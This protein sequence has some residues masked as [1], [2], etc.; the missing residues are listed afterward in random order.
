[1]PAPS[2]N[3]LLAAAL[4]YLE[5]GWSILPVNSGGKWDKRPHQALK[6]TGHTQ[7]IDGET[8]AAWKLLQTERPTQEQVKK[9]F[10][11]EVGKGVALVTGAISGIV[12]LDF[13]GE[14]GVALMKALG[15]NPHART[16]SGGYHVYLK[17][18]GF[19]VQTLNSKAKHEL[20]ERWP[21]LDIRADGGYAILPPSRNNSGPYQQLRSF[22]DLDDVAVLPEELAAYLGLIQVQRPVTSPAPSRPVRQHFVPSGN[23]VPAELILERALRHV[24]G[25]GRNNAGMWLACQLRDNGYSEIESGAVMGNYVAQVPATNAKGQHEPYTVAEAHATLRSAYSQPARRPWEQSDSFTAGDAGLPAD[26]AVQASAPSNDL[27]DVGT[28][29]VVPSNIKKRVTPY[30]RS[31]ANKFVVRVQTELTEG[32][33]LKLR[34]EQRA[35]FVHRAGSEFARRLDKAGVEWYALIATL[36]E[37]APPEELLNQL[38]DLGLAVVERHLQGDAQYLLE[39]LPVLLDARAQRNVFYPI[40]LPQLDAALGGGLY[41]GLHVLGGATAGGKTALAL[42]AAEQNAR[43]ER[44]V[45]FV[46]YEQS[47]AELWTRLISSRVGISVSQLRKGGTAEEPVG[48]LLT[49]K[50]EYRELASSVAPYLRIFEGDG[51]SGAQQW[52]VERIAAE[53]R[54]VRATF[55]QSPLVI[56]DYLQRMP[57]QVDADKRH[58]IDEVVSAL[59]V[60]LGREEE[61]PILLLSSVSRGNYGELLTRS[62]DERL[63]VFKESGGIEYTAYSA[64]LI[65]PLS[66]ENAMQLGLPSAPASETSAAL[67][68]NWRYLVVDLVKNREG[69]PGLQL[70]VKWWPRSARYEVVCPV[71]SN[72]LTGE[73][74][75][76]RRAGR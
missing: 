4:S 64:M 44:P 31:Q 16:G 1:M 26:S 32:Y 22:D 25:E 56:L 6:D 54:R 2:A 41:P 48:T 74:F 70:I 58:R 19:S 33:L 12:V 28:V 23:R 49:G 38:E 68:G 57:S 36:D 73:S 75:K 67:L 62:L 43:A 72:E 3:S 9:W 76:A 15:L 21:G 71:D 69:E 17:H 37:Q 34:Q 50:A 53:V 51:S 20:G 8:K 35:V 47:R 65:Y 39:E 63:V 59:Q 42:H 27:P 61:T 5:L 55:G 10:A 11:R 52:G 14:Q 7:L 13:D 45:L 29:Y 60:Q 30:L 40:G 46:T 18:P 66:A 24:Q